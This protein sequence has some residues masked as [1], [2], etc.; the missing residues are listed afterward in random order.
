MGNL[1]SGVAV[2]GP[3]VFNVFGIKDNIAGED[4]GESTITWSNAPGNDLDGHSSMGADAILLGTF[5]LDGQ[6]T[7]GE[8]ITFSNSN[9]INYLNDD[10]NN[11]VSFAISRETI[12]NDT[13][14]WIHNFA[15]K[16]HS[17]YDAPMLDLTYSIPEISNIYLIGIFI[18]CVVIY[19]LK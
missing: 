16:E 14:G 13:G 9:L 15:S 11:I 2:T 19:R 18:V 12:Q 10:T 1:N 4:W 17:I 7:P 5:T 6:G 3:Q 8:V